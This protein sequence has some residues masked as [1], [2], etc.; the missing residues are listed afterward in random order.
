MSDLLKEVFISI[1]TPYKIAQGQVNKLHLKA[2]IQL[3]FQNNSKLEYG[4]IDQIRHEIGEN[5]GLK[6]CIGWNGINMWKIDNELKG[7]KDT[8]R[9][10]QV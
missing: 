7:L 6:M 1:T 8:F 4:Q 2:M 9:S 3:L 5:V 10:V